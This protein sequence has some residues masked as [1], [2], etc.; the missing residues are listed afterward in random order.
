MTKAT[1]QSVKREVVQLY[2]E[3]HTGEWIA[4]KRVVKSPGNVSKILRDFRSECKVDI[5]AAAKKYGVEDTIER[6][7]DL[8]VDMLEN[9]LSL[10]EAIDGIEFR[11]ELNSR[12][13]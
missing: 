6:T 2:L 5:V 12:M 9:K 10:E 4:K 8:N 7:H 3:G 11:A 1:P 13:S